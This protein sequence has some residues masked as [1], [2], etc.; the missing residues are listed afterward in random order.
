MLLSPPQ[1][2]FSEAST[3]GDSTYS[4]VDALFGFTAHSEQPADQT[5]VDSAPIPKQSRMLPDAKGKLIY[6]GQSASLSYLHIV[7]RVAAD[8]IG[9]CAFT[10][11]PQQQYI[12]E[13]E[14]TSHLGNCPEP[15]PDLERSLALAEQYEL[16]VSGVFD[17]FDIS[18]LQNAIPPWV[19]D[20]SRRDRPE[21]PVIF[22]ALAIGAL[23]RAAD[24]KD[25][26][27]AETYFNYGRQQ[28]VIY[29]MDDPCL[30]TVVAFSL[31]SYYMLASCRRNGAFTNI[32]IAARAA[33]ALGI[34]R[35][36]TNRAFG[37]GARERAW[38]SL[39]VCDLFLSASMGRPPATSEADC[40][41]PWSKSFAKMNNGDYKDDRSVP[42][43]EDSA[44][45]RICL[46]FERILV[47]VFSRRAVSLDLAGSISQQHRQWTE[48]LPSMLKIDGLLRNDT[49]T[50]ASIQKLGTHIVTM[51][52]YY[53]ITLLCRPFLSFHVGTRLKKAGNYQDPEAYSDFITTYADACIDSAVKGIALAHEIVFDESMPKR[54][55]LIINSVFIS[56]LCLGHA[57]FGDY[58]Q[59]GWPLNYNIDTAISILRKLGLKNPQA[60]R[61]CEICCYLK[62]VVG[63]YTHRRA[64][65]LL[66]SPSSNVRSMFGDIQAIRINTPHFSKDADAD[67]FHDRNIERFSIGQNHAL[68]A[69]NK[70]I[71]CNDNNINDFAGSTILPPNSISTP[72]SLMHLASLPQDDNEFHEAVNKHCDQ[73][74]DVESEYTP[75]MNNFAFSDTLPLFSLID[76]INPSLG[77][78][79]SVLLGYI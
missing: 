54:Q 3:F 25:E 50:K 73:N 9:S 21:T 14:F 19:A 61:Y 43:Q 52:Y 75:T 67:D 12:L 49:S 30:M 58:D 15:E 8:C 79:H 63:T 20:P 74:L 48:E 32:G 11:D 56:A 34:H 22:L 64:D 18:Y 31:I 7:Q 77:A 71:N 69:Q 62:E 6:I 42:T 39:R 57:I 13:K 41:I 70:I 23:G 53:S 5:I 24:D 36:E 65:T 4:E 37:G 27:I 59:R 66:R 78:D 47:E 46:I 33:Y 35:H 2:H 26:D 44:I 40:N 17:F 45:F 68:A 55:P 38:K 72:E 60:A 51:A 1:F 16:A 10:D 29:L 76:G 28:A